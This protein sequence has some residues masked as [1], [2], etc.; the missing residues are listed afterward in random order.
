MIL[1]EFVPA[2]DATTVAKLHAAGA[3]M[4]GKL[5]MT[6]W[7]TPLTLAISLRAALQS[8]ER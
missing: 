5:N 8:L 4:L 6:E 7:A 3:I 1:S 2:Y